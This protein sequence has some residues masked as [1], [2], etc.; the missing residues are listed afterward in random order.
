MCYLIDKYAP[1]YLE[2]KI[3]ESRSSVR[4][5]LSNQVRAT[6]G[7]TLDCH[8]TVISHCEFTVIPYLPLLPPFQPEVSHQHNARVWSSCLCILPECY[9]TNNMHRYNRVRH[10]N[11]IKALPVP[12]LKLFVSKAD[13]APASRETRIGLAAAL[14][15]AARTGLTSTSS[16]L[17]GSETWAQFTIQDTQNINKKHVYTLV[18]SKSSVIIPSYSLEAVILHAWLAQSWFNVLYRF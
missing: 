6:L 17:Q 5:L 16:V 11:M 7:F 10:G 18:A 14:A 15:T 3:H 9:A 4:Y 8:R 2:K 12:N 13:K 1:F